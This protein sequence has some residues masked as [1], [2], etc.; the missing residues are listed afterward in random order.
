MTQE[1]LNDELDRRIDD[2]YLFGK[3]SHEDVMRIAGELAADHRVDFEMDA[4]TQ[5]VIWIL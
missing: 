3:P 5:E 1:F 4:D 2:S